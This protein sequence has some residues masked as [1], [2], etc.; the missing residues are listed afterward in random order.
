[1]S[2]KEDALTAKRLRKLLHYDKDT[3]HFIR[4]VPVVT[5][6]GG[7]HEDVGTRAGGFNPSDG[8][9]YTQISGYQ[10]SEHRLAFLWVMGSWPKGQID[11]INGVR[12]DNRWAN[13]R[14]VTVR[15]NRQNSR[16]TRSRIGPYPGVYAY[17]R[18]RTRFIAQI[19]HNS[20]VH[21][22]GIHET[23]ED[24]YIARIVAELELFGEHA[25]C[26]RPEYEL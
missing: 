19:K 13:L 5:Y 8:Y 20:E 11:H 3:G 1:M 4:L 14:D 18:D 7:I 12:D 2:K 17:P 15:Q 9:R 10:Y 24:A 23:A 22:L 16:G 6:R 25:G 21:Y 26:L